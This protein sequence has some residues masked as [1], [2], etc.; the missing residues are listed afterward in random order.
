MET[1]KK[2]GGSILK[3]I[4]E[5]NQNELS[6]KLQ[7]KNKLV[8]PTKTT[9]YR[10]YFSCNA[11]NALKLRRVC[12]KLRKWNQTK[13]RIFKC[14][15]NFCTK[16]FLINCRVFALNTLR[17]SVSRSFGSSI[18]LSSAFSSLVIAKCK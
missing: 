10:D 17:R 12:G 16:T 8:L 18:T 3:T 7:H 15:H 6:L 1:G 5:M 2:S 9:T 13:R 14:F 4:H 11:T